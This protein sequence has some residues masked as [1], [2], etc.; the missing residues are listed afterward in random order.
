MNFEK[1]NN[2]AT[3]TICGL[4]KV[5]NMLHYINEKFFH[6]CLFIED[7]F[8]GKKKKVTNLTIRS[9]PESLR[10]VRVITRVTPPCISCE[11]SRHQELDSGKYKGI[12]LESEFVFNVLV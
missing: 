8:Q 9:Y 11:P 10:A 5:L 6:F 7:K 1:R 4:Q 12:S 3:L 2:Q